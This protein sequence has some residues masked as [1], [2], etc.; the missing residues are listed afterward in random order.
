MKSEPLDIALDEVLAIEVTKDI[1]ISVD[2]A[3]STAAS[4]LKP[5]QQ[6][7]AVRLQPDYAWPEFGIL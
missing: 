7:K 3:I 6:Q 2:S 5:N 1:S 4:S